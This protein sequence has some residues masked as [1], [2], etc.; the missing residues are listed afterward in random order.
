MLQK[1]VL[2]I[3]LSV[4]LAACGGDDISDFVE[5]SDIRLLSLEVVEGGTLLFEENEVEEFDPGNIGPYRVELADQ[6]L[7]SITIRA[8]IANVDG[9]RLELVEFAK[10]DEDDDRVTAVSP[11]EIVTVSVEEG[12]NL[13]A[14][15]VSSLTSAARIDYVMR[16]NKISSSAVLSDILVFGVRSSNES[17]NVQ[18]S[19]EVAAD[20]FEYDVTLSSLVWSPR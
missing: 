4:F 10:G 12:A 20:I 9:V 5:V 11:N 2:I 17:S 1:A 6:S 18:F 15:R 7:T 8:G 3:S 14:I 13:V 16:I 19:N